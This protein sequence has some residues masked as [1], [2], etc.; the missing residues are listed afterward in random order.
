MGKNNYLLTACRREGCKFWKN[1][2]A[3][4]GSSGLALAAAC[5]CC[6]K[7]CCARTSSWIAG[8]KAAKNSGLTS[9]GPVNSSTTVACARCRIR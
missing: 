8:G 4:T 7:R 6:S 9:T 1:A 3:S 2:A 5:R